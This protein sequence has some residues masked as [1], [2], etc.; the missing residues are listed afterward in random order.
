MINIVEH[1]GF[2]ADHDKPWRLKTSCNTPRITLS[3]IYCP[4]R[5][6]DSTKWYQIS[7]FRA[8]QINDLDVALD[9]VSWQGNKLGK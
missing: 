5:H 7:F 8:M 1:H 2:M 3:K 4:S 6:Y 9:R